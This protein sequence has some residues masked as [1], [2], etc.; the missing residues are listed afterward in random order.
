MR[1]GHPRR[2]RVKVPTQLQFEVAECGAACIGMV[3]GHFGR[4]VALDE[5][6]VACGVSRDGVKASSLVR[7]AESYGMVVKGYRRE[8]EQLRSMSFPLIAHWKFSHFVVVEGYHPGG[9]YL[10]D[11]AT[12]PRGCTDEEFAT[13]FTGVILEPTIG[14]DFTPGGARPGIFERLI[15]AAGQRRGAGAALLILG[16]LLVVPILIVP[17]VLSRF[18]Q[19]L[20]GF[21]GLEPVPTVTALILAVVIQAAILT[22]QGGIAVNM[23]SKITVRLSSAMVLRLLRLPVGFHA[24]RGASMLARRAGVANQLSEAISALTISA[25]TSAF[26]ASTSALILIA[27]DPASGIV[28]V[29]IGV[30]MLVVLGQVMRRSRDLAQREVR[31]EAELGVVVTSAL[32]QIEAIKAGGAESG[33]IARGTAAQHTYL[34]TT[35]LVGMRTAVLSMWPVLIGG[36]GSIAVIGVATVRISAGALEPGAFLSIQALAAGVIGP[37]GVIAIALDRAQTLRASLDQVDDI[38]DAPED[39]R[40]TRHHDEDVPV[41]IAGAVEVDHVTFGYG[42]QSAPTV[43]GVDLR[44]D[45]GQR[46]AIVGP[47]GCGKSTVARLVAGL[48]V[49]WEGEIR[50]DGRPRSRH[51]SEVLIDSVGHVDQQVSIFSGTIRDNVTLWDAT[52]P[53]TDV[54]AAIADAQ[55]TDEIAERPGGL[56]SM[57]AEGGADLSGGQRQRLEIARAL[58]RNPSILIMDEATSALDAT[59][60]LLIDN[61]IR[62]RGVTTLVIAHRLSTIRDSDEIICLDRGT[63][64]ERGTHDELTALGGMYADLVSSM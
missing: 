18:G 43:S 56:D 20:A 55:L 63:V 24:Q 39:A 8:P 26:M 58:V 15:R 2:L 11:P 1:T 23:A 62:R 29:A 25:F 46:K 35:Q 9:W 19:H 44:L 30:A 52:I 61:A 54:L 38:L 50:F 37:I 10:N 47:S 14:P 42:T 13:S 45:P 12:G 31:D 41:S 51:A 64:V 27:F 57:L 21:G 28:A 34:G 5:L 40:F 17:Q 6:R 59:T 32:L 48:Y 53:D 22:V 60:E 4:F 3:L 16:A 7:A 36:L 49:P 33:V